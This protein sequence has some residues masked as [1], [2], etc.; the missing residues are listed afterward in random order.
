MNLHKSNIWIQLANL[1]KR[2]ILQLVS[3]TE[4]MW[5]LFCQQR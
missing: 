2:Y 1:N 4:Q 3:Y 5:Y